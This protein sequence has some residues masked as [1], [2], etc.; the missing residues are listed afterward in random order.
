MH[1]NE[2]GKLI[3]AR[4]GSPIAIGVG[5][6]EYYIASDTSP[7]LAHTQQ[8]LFL[9]DGEIAEITDKGVQLFTLED[10]KIYKNPEHIEWAGHGV[11]HFM[12]CF[13]R[14]H[15]NLFTLGFYE[16][17]AAV[18]PH[19]ELFASM[20]ARYLYSQE[21]K[22][23]QDQALLEIARNERGDLRGPIHMID[24]PRHTY[25]CDWLT[26]RKRVRRLYRQLG[27]PMPSA[28]DFATLKAD[29]DTQMQIATRHV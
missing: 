2:P 20:V 10:Q 19:L 15:P 17:N 18:F 26:F 21:Q 7:M 12:T 13:S 5:D 9:D 4:L 3:A 23:G 6:G 22:T 14:Q 8:V 27:W 1:S 25:Y 24:S 11:G 28:E 16:G 29:P